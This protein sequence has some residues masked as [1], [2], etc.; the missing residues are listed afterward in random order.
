MGKWGKT[1]D[2]VP[3]IMMLKRWAMCNWN[4]ERDLQVVKL[5]KAFLLFEFQSMHE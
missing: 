1:S 2:Y 3:N 5:R 4:L